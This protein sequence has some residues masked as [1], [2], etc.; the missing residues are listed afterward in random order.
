MSNICPNCKTELK[1][2]P[3]CGLLYSCAI[4]KEFFT[5]EYLKTKENS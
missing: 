5:I 1:L 4:C 2:V 3:Q